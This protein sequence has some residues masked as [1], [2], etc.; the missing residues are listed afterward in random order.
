MKVISEINGSGLFAQSALSA[1][2]AS[3]DSLGNEITATYATK[4]EIPSL[5][6]LMET[7]KLEFDS[8]NK[9]TAYNGSAFA[10][11]SSTSDLVYFDYENGTPE[12][13]WN[14]IQAYMDAGK[15]LIIYDRN[16]VSDGKTKFGYVSNYN[17]A[18]KFIQFNNV[19]NTTSGTTPITGIN[20]AYLGNS[21]GWQR[22]GAQ[23]GQGGSTYTT[24]DT[25]YLNI[26]NLDSKIN[27]TDKTKN[28]IDNVP[29]GTNYDLVGGEN[30][31]FTV[32]DTEHQ[33]VIDVEAPLSTYQIFDYGTSLSAQ[34][35]I[36]CWKSG[37]IPVLRIP[38]Y[39]ALL[40][41]CRL[42]TVDPTTLTTAQYQYF[43]CNYNAS[44][45]TAYLYSTNSRASGLFTACN[46][47]TYTSYTANANKWLSAVSSQS[48]NWNTVSSLSAEKEDKITFGYNDGKIVS[49]NGSALSAGSNYEGSG[50][51]TVNNE[52]KVIGARTREVGMTTFTHDNTLSHTEVDG[53]YTLSVVGGGTSEISTVSPITGNGTAESPIGANTLDVNFQ[54]ITH[55]DSLVHVSNEAGY[56][57][58]VN[59]PL[60]SQIQDHLKVVSSKSITLDTAYC[61]GGSLTAS[62]LSNGM[63]HIH[64]IIR[65][66]GAITGKWTASAI[67]SGA[68]KSLVGDSL[69][70]RTDYSGYRNS[71][72]IDENGNVLIYARELAPSG[73]VNV[74]NGYY[75]YGGV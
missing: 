6:G 57:L 61:S 74:V 58:G 68:F 43:G 10:G 70:L 54:Q 3:Y 46:Q 28:A 36:D 66:N 20:W 42:P 48:A 34:Q 38:G 12:L 65:F 56:A 41:P 73:T 21:L 47:S 11:Q 40:W 32:D 19:G 18:D 2:T 39:S 14:E 17:K 23:G 69:P 45:F 15:Q 51:I 25:E 60:V 13:T 22:T 55:D 52:T 62:L 9:I 63:C 44:A 64:G 8:N 1:S 35:T 7:D 4:S 31:K 49:M 24:D 16:A 50:P 59:I 72:G 30:I 33:I 26:N 53:V 75:S 37:K 5:D 71:V 29:T 67:A 27:F